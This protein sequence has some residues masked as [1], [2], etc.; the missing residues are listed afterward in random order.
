VQI[1]DTVGNTTVTT[2]NLAGWRTQLQDPT[3]GLSTFTFD[4]NGRVL[5]EKNALGA[6][7]TYQCD[8]ASKLIKKLLGSA[9]QYTYEFGTSGTGNGLLIHTT[10]PAGTTDMVYDLRGRVVTRT[11][12]IATSTY[13]TRYTYDSLGRVRNLH[14]PDGFFVDYTYGTDGRTSQVTDDKGRIIVSR[15]EPSE[16]PQIVPNSSRNIAC[17]RSMRSYCLIRGSNH[18][19]RIFG[20]A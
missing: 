20:I 17:S 6:T 15:I 19:R 18:S 11:R 3:R 2:Y 13:I 5:S 16:S 14:Y 7:T 10:E 8:A 12:K 4:A 9:G 1:V